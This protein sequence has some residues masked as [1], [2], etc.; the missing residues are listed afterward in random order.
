MP[1]NLFLSEEYRTNASSESSD[2]WFGNNSYDWNKPVEFDKKTAEVNFA[3][4]GVFE[5][6]YFTRTI[7]GEGET[8]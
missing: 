1:W 3:I 7:L 5:G 8:W 6:R 2:G 4:Q